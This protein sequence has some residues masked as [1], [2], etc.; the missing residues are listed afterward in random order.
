M[1]LS[2]TQI[3]QHIPKIGESTMSAQNNSQELL[4]QYI[5]SIKDQ[6]ERKK[7]EHLVRLSSLNIGFAIFLSLLIPIGGYFYTRRWKAFLYLICSVSLMGGI[8]GGNPRTEKE[9]LE[10]GLM[11]GSIIGTIVAPID[12]ALAISRAKK[13]IEELSK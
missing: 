6:E 2:K 3:I 4:H 11:I 7:A 13:Q 12:N 9:A 1:L 5:D 10:R 8:I